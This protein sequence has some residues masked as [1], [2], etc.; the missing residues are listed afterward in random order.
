MVKISNL[1]KTALISAFALYAG[2]CSKSPSK[3]SDLFESYNL[4]DLTS[5]TMRERITTLR[6]IYDVV[7]P[8]SNCLVA[9]YKRNL[10]TF[11]KNT[12]ILDNEG[13][14]IGRTKTPMLQWGYNTDIFD[15]NEDIAYKIDHSV[16][17]S[18]INFNGFV[19]DI[20]DSQNNSVGTL[21]QDPISLLSRGELRYFEIKDVNDNIL[22]DIS[23]SFHLNDTYSINNYDPQVLPNKVLGAVVSLIDQIRDDYKN[24][25]KSQSSS[26]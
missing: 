12:R 11:T 9:T 10:V 20:K 5:Y 17:R 26:E 4:E 15:A 14:T 21:K 13:V 25:S 1:A 19:M 24:S 7:E 18:F 16:I 6:P 3:C 2:S 8:N 23:H 22:A